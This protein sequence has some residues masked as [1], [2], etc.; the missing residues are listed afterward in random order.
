MFIL[1]TKTLVHL[2]DKVYS[3]KHQSAQKDSR[4]TNGF[5]CTKVAVNN[6]T[7]LNVGQVKTSGQSYAEANQSFLGI[8]RALTGSEH[9]HALRCRQGSCMH[10]IITYVIYNLLL[11]PTIYCTQ[12]SCKVLL[13][14]HADE[15]HVSSHV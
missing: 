4:F 6:G 10:N 5:D 12:P 7:F 9:E 8:F 1:K 13:L 14:V 2:A 3:C 15:T 11:T